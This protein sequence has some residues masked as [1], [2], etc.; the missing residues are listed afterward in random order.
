MH[1]QKNIKYVCHV[2]IKPIARICHW[3]EAALHKITIILCV[4]SGFR[5]RVDDTR[6]LLEYYSA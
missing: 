2:V 3:A 4:T 6:A 1:G 5:R